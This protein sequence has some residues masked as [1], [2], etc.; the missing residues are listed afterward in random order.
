MRFRSKGQPSGFLR[1]RDQRRLTLAIAGVGLLVILISIL[2]RP[3]ARKAGLPRD[4]GRESTG[5]RREI[6][7]SLL[8]TDSLQPDEILVVPAAT[9]S[10]AAPLDLKSLLDPAEAARLDSESRRPALQGEP[11]DT[12]VPEHLLRPVRDDIL[13]VHSQEVESYFATLRLAGARKNTD[14]EAREAARYAVFMDSPEFC[15]GRAF[16]VTGTLR[17]LTRL[18]DE[19][20]SFGLKT[21]YD[22]WISLPDSGTQLVHVVAVS[23][24]A[25]LPLTEHTASEPPRVQFEAFYFKREGYLRAGNDADGDIGLTPLLLAGRIRKFLPPDASDSPAAALTPWLGWLTLLVS[26]GIALLIWQFRS[27]D[28]V[29][30]RTRTHQLTQLPVRVSFDGIPAMTVAESLQQMESGSRH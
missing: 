5:A 15:R 24:D 11:F 23:A 10:D 20:N 7:E 21:L 26:G 4:S 14:Q 28:R 29:F 8:G 9:T 6:T 2:W 3:D 17:R 18:Q 27:S 1:P 30:R 13:G 12:A 19:T 16:L 22:A 25:G